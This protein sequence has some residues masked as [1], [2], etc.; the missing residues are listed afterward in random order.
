MSV[1]VGP[2]QFTSDIYSTWPKAVT[3]VSLPHKFQFETDKMDERIEPCH[4]RVVVFRN[5]FRSFRVRESDS[6]VPTSRLRLQ[7][8][9]ETEVLKRRFKW[10]KEGI[11][12]YHDL[13]VTL[14]CAQ[15]SYIE[16]GDAESVES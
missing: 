2:N 12:L 15:D 9:V 1:Q 13:Y 14:K 16:Q 11:Y 3:D 7:T 10:N 4:H 8:K 5:F 6:I